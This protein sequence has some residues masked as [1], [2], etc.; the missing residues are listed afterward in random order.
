MKVPDSLSLAFGKDFE[1]L[2]SDF[3]HRENLMDADIALNSQRFLSR[4][5]APHIEKLS[6]LFNREEK[7]QSSGLP[8]YWKNSSNP[9]HLRLAYFLYFM[10]CNVFRMASIWAELSRLG[11]K[12]KPEQL[13]GI[14]FGAGPASGLCGIA[15][16]E[17]F[18]SVDAPASAQWALIEQD[19]SILELGARW[20]ETY[21]RSLGKTDWSTRTFHRKIDLKRGFLPKTAP[22]FNL[23]LMSFYLNE[24]EL[25]AEELACLLLDS[26]DDHLEQ[27][28]LVILMEPALRLQ[29]RR[30]LELRKA[31]LLEQKK[32]K[33]ND[34]Q[35]L[36]PCLGHQNCGALANPEDWCHEEVTWW[37]P[38]YLRKLDEL[39]HLDRKKLPF[40]YLV[41]IKSQRSREDIL[42]VLKQSAEAQRH[43]LVSPAHAE[44][45]DLEFFTCSPEG[46]RRAR[47]RPKNEAEESINRGDILL[48]TEIRGDENASRI[49]SIQTKVE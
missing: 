8:A 29:S 9:Q 4:A 45:R 39:T 30:L 40:S 16:G 13:R 19:Q 27:E 7:D 49:V 48:G 6:S 37:R 43:R 46:K 10:P 25:P 24:L 23:W 42:P 31:L 33:Q 34:Y 28:G 17:T 26:W 11:F 47:Y 21:T 15:A 44:G 14:E 3:V 18:A 12:W 1:A 20:A 2:L 35:I 41:I 22:E 5:I 38:P 32:R 36:L